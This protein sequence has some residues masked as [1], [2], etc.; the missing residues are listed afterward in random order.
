MV[1]EEC[2]YAGGV[3]CSDCFSSPSACHV[4][5]DGIAHKE[6]VLV[7]AHDG[8]HS[9]I[10]RTAGT[11]A[12]K[13]VE[14]SDLVESTTVSLD[15]CCCPI[16]YGNDPG[17]GYSPPGCTENHGAGGDAGPVCGNCVLRTLASQGRIFYSGA[18]P[19]ATACLSCFRACFKEKEVEAVQQ[20]FN[21]AVNA[22]EAE[23]KMAAES[24]SSTYDVAASDE[25]GGSSVT[26]PVSTVLRA[27][28]APYRHVI[29]EQAVLT[30]NQSLRS[31]F[32]CKC[33]EWGHEVARSG[34]E[35]NTAYVIANGKEGEPQLGMSGF[36]ALVRD[37]LMQ[38]HPQA[39]LHAAVEVL[40]G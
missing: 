24:D 4:G 31:A 14:L 13:Q 19:P 36:K 17:P 38:V 3:F 5:T 25:T 37:L 18:S 11:D 39:H 32:R 22:F 35:E 26:L 30:G 20:E 10:Q 12:I 33:K 15:E 6:W 1:D 2:G 28:L 16:C 21:V 27:C 9:G 8:K 23:A 7:S 40:R 29:N 34:R